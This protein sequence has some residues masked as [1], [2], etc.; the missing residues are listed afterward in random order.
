M[1]VIRRVFVVDRLIGVVPRVGG[2]HWL[3]DGDV[4][5]VLVMD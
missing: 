5:R 4:L 2:V 1:R 3:D